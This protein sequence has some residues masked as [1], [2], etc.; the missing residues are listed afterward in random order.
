MGEKSSNVPTAKAPSV[1]PLK[2]V[3][4][5]AP[6][7]GNEKELKKESTAPMT[8]E[9]SK[10]SNENVVKSKDSKESKESKESKS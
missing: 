6:K 8:S 1:V 4:P 2:T 5:E 3:K 7:H 9:A 10:T